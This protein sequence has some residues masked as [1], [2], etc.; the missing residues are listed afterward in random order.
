M[1]INKTATAG[2]NISFANDIEAEF[3]SGGK[4]NETRRLGKY[5]RDD[6]GFRNKNVGEMTNMP[7]DKEGNFPTSV[8]IGSSQIAFSDFCGR[9]L[10]VVISYDVNQDNPLSGSD[11]FDG[12][13]EKRVVGGFRSASSVTSSQ[14]TRVT[15]H[16]HDGVSIGSEKGTSTSEESR[17]RSALTTGNGWE[18]D[19]EL[20]IN[21][22]G[23]VCGG[24]GNGGDG[25]EDPN[26][27][28]D[29]RPG[30]NGNSAIGI[31][32]NVETLTLQSGGIIRAGAGGGGGAGAGKEDSDTPNRRASGGGGGGGAGIPA[33]DGGISR[34][35]EQDSGP[36]AGGTNGAPG[37]GLNAGGNGGNGGNQGDEA[38]GGGGGGGGAFISGGQGSGGVRG[39]DGDGPDP[40]DGNAGGTNGNGGGG[41]KGGRTDEGERSF[42]GLGGD[43]GYSIIRTNNATYSQ[44][45]NSGD[46]LGPQV[47]VPG[48]VSGEF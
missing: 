16:V 24:G 43:P 28:G 12:N 14:G 42:G 5:R 40:S 6:A 22:A 41:G 15:L 29:G 30:L 2:Q 27:F 23:T 25:S 21:I 11:K 46:L 18:T 37:G 8:A 39:G 38:F 34:A 36:F 17:Y 7:L 19:T 48:D 44:F 26:S 31:S 4:V 9:Q 35:H 3:G 20:D 45:N 33:G 47:V 13:N 32:Y 10:N 1:T